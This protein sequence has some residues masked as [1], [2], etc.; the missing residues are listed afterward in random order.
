MSAAVSQ[1]HLDDE[2]QAEPLG[3]ITALFH[4][5]DGCPLV[6]T[7][8]EPSVP[9]RATVVLNAATGVP[10]RFYGPFA[11]HLAR[12]GLATLTWDY[13]GIG[14]SAPASLR[15]FAATKQDWGRLDMS[16]AFGWL[17]DRFPGAPRTVLG[18]S[19]GGQL[20]GLMDA[21]DRIDAVVTI[22]CGFG[23]W[24]HIAGPYRF[25]VAGLWYLV[26]PAATRLA[27]YLP[28]RRLGLGED[29]PTGVALEWARWGKQ[30]RYFSD[31]LGQEAGFAEL[32]APWRAFI[33]SD[34]PI[35]TLDNVRPLHALYKNARI[36]LEVLDPEA[37]GFDSIGHLGFFSRRRRA[38]WDRPVDWLLDAVRER[39][40]G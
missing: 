16:A 23:Y 1:N 34:D 12:H 31:E 18:H 21:P 3:P 6:G 9:I 39:A 8:F 5:T 24:G 2:R 38:L 20:I 13:R 32:K 30:A 15:G 10:R 27:G 7:L 19:V 33:L 25:V 11:A 35:A 26:I 36:D 29:L 22:G 37:F 40:E 4:A 14:D 28:A 17:A